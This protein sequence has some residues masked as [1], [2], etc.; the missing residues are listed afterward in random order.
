MP[1]K[2]K[3]ETKQD[4]EYVSLSQVTELLNQQ[5]E[6][7][8]LLMHQQQDNFK[9]FVQ[10]ILENFNSRL[11]TMSK[12]LQDIK[13]S[14]QFT[15]RDVDD[16]K[17]GLGK[18]SENHNLLQGDFMKMSDSLLTVTGKLEYLEGQS[19]QNNLLFDGVDESPGESW[20]E[21]EVKIKNVLFEKL[22]IQRNLEL[23]RVFRSGRRRDEKDRPRPILVKFQKHKDKVEVLQKA[24]CLKGTKIFINED[25]TDAVRLRRKEL[26][27]KMRAARERGDIAF[28]RHDQLIIHPRTNTSKPTSETE[29]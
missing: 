3:S 1:A 7:F 21:A 23:E 2:P 5:K 10:L 13:T 25:F 11:D 26:L 22:N 17:D 14:L 19:R 18:H 20:T 29:A 9:G 8:N 4:D 24:K 15:Q 6:M 16:I 12:E 28:L 27:P